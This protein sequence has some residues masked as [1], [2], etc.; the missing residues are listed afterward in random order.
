MSS[1]TAP[2]VHMYTIVFTFILTAFS[3][4]A[5]IFFLG[6]WVATTWPALTITTNLLLGVSFLVVGIL[7]LTSGIFLLG[8]GRK[9]SGS[10]G[11]VTAGV[12]GMI[13][14]LFGY[15]PLNIS[16]VALSVI[17]LI[18]SF[19][20]VI[21]CVITYS[22]LRRVPPPPPPII[23][24]IPGPPLPPPKYA[25]KVFTPE[26]D[27]SICLLPFEATD[28]VYRCPSCGSSFHEGCGRAWIDLN[29]TCARCRTSLAI[30]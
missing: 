17:G 29:K 3:F 22:E 19:L 15:N 27:C 10:I 21:T 7:C 25:E 2:T 18:F 6:A 5:G 8:Y 13:L 28:S 20:V 26:G 16:T 14:S 30:A 4:V 24:P 1:Q 23:P 9:S 11:G 12:L